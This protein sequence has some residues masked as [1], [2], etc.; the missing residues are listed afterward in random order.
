[1]V[2]LQSLQSEILEILKEHKSMK[3]LELRKRFSYSPIVILQAASKLKDK[4]LINYSLEN[5]EITLNVK[6]FFEQEKEKN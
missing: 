3:M 5:D 2:V 6:S 1:M 4:K